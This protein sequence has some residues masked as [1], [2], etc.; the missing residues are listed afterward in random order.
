MQPS[1]HPHQQLAPY[2]RIG[3][4]VKSAVTRVPGALGSEEWDSYPHVIARLN[5]QWRVIACRDDLQW[6]LQARRGTQDGRPRW[7]NRYSFRTR[8]GVVCGSHEYAGEIAGDAL[9]VLLW[10]PE[11]LDGGQA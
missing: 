11:H 1:F 9:I 10:L 8:Q 2:R 5:S 4:A 3:P 6:I 7:R